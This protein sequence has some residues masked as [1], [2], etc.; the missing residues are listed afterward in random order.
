MHILGYLL[1]GVGFLL[2]ALSAVW[3]VEGILQ[4]LYATGV[5]LG[6]AGVLL[7]RIGTRRIHKSEERMT[8]N[9]GTIRSSLQ[10]LAA[11]VDSLDDNKEDTF[12][13]DIHDLID[14]TTIDSIE[15]FVDVRESVAH[16]FGLQPYADLMSHFAAGERALNRAWSASTDGYID[17]VSTSLSRARSEFALTVQALDHIEQK[18]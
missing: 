12:V 7:A 10:A 18:A 17:E 5:G 16:A 11:A 9:L 3:Q 14:D 6:V 4:G 15:S 2:G 13:Y 8:E 1:I